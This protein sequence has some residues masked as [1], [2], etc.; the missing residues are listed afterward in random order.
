VKHSIPPRPSG[1]GSSRGR[2]SARAEAEALRSEIV[3]IEERIREVRRGDGHTPQRL[4]RAMELLADIERDLHA[5]AARCGDGGPAAPA[6]DAAAVLADVQQMRSAC[7]RLGL[8][9]CVRRADAVIAGHVEKSARAWGEGLRPELGRLDADGCFRS[10]IETTALDLEARR[11]MPGG[12]TDGETFL[13]FRATLRV[14]LVQAARKSP[15]GADVRAEWTRELI[16]RGDT[17]LTSVEGEPPD[18]AAALLGVVEADITWHLEHVETA[19]GPNRRRLLRKRW[20]LRVEQQERVLQG[21]LQRRFGPTLVR[22]FERLI[23]VLIAL[24]VPL[25]FVEAAADL[26]RTTQIWI[27]VFDGA[28]CLLFLTEFFVKLW[29]VPGKWLWFR[30]HALIDLVPSIPIGLLLFTFPAAGGVNAWIKGFRLWR[31]ARYLRAFGLVSRGLDRLARQY[32]HLLNQNVILYPTREELARSWAA[33]PVRATGL[34]RLRRELRDC[35]KHLVRTADEGERLRVAMS[36]LDVLEDVLDRS[37]ACGA[38][39]RRRAPGHAREVAAEVL[40]DNLVVM[41]AEDAEAALGDELVSQTA[42]IVRAAAWAP[43]RWLPIISSVVP[44]LT[45][46]MSDAEITAAT[47]RR[48]GRL[49]KRLHG[50]WFWV[51]DLYGTVTPSQ[52]VDRV[53]TMLVRSSSRPAYRLVMFGGLYVLTLLLIAWLR[54][55]ELDPVK[56]F[57]ER[58]VGPLVLVLGIVAGLVLGV[59]IWLQRVAQEATEFYERSAKAQ[60]LHLTEVI[61]SRYLRRDAGVLYDRILRSEWCPDPGSCGPLR[62]HHLAVVLEHIHGSLTEATV[63]TDDDALYRGFDTVLLLYRDWLDGAILTDNDTRST[64]QLLGNPAVRQIIMLSGR[65]GRGE[66]KRL[67][68]LDLERQKAL[69]GGPYLWFNFICRAVAHSV[70]SLLVDYNQNAVRLTE[71]PLLGPPARQRYNRWLGAA[72]EESLKT[73][74]TDEARVEEHYV[75]TVFTA[76]HFLDFDP[77]RDAEVAQE[78]GEPVLARLRRDRS[79]LIRTIFGTYP[80]HNRPKE[81]RV[82]NLYSLYGSWLSGGRLVLLPLFVAMLGLR[83]LWALLKWIGRSVQEVRRPEKRRD[84][85][86]AAQAHFLTAVR[87]VERIRGPVVYAGLRLRARLDAEY[88][89]VP[90]PNLP[91][92]PLPADVDIDLDFLHAEPDVIREVEDERRRAAADM[93][94]L[95]VLF[96]GGLLARAARRRALPEDAFSSA[97]HHRAAAV[98]YLSDMRG[99]RRHL[100]ADRIVEEVI[101][102]AVTE[103]PSAAPWRPAPRLRRA[104]RRYWKQHGIGDRLGRRAAWRAVRRNTWGAADSL[105]AAHRHGAKA[106]DEG[107]RLLGELL[108]H[109]SRIIDQLVTV[110]AIQTLAV[111]D[112]LNYREHIHALGRYAD[113]GDLPGELLDWN[114]DR[115][116]AF[117]E[118]PTTGQQAIAG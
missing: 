109:P 48:C 100:S 56:L 113:S 28:A 69:F 59:G 74:D 86:E 1:S 94:R 52:F 90:L 71:L 6:H 45:A 83:L 93:D 91:P 77:Q 67:Q 54:I 88:L 12:R 117:P 63:G 30:R 23:L 53:G 70:A 8:D 26:S 72:T 96:E 27:N 9:E 104:F 24:V 36:R 98:A 16:D 10:L 103:P 92:P 47:A 55:T 78:F 38:D 37:V 25:V 13:E 76:L 105:M 107:E 35:W 95:R 118:A 57:L 108:L 81:Q 42:R 34:R 75:T 50:A 80:M 5:L 111:L 21:R 20:Q 79:F 3:A 112:V 106:A 18:R 41:T 11:H 89:G 114:T 60:F 2:Q 31:F 116:A 46:G 39:V 40:I 84:H 15:P 64:S 19:G 99:V 22:R 49:L 85:S 4:G 110:R 82:V 32:G 97:D 14:A 68:R 61:R 33:V 43:L 58:S 101:A 115:A 73:T 62:D 44:R 7:E 65:I 17:A 102:Q 87:K 66:E 51:A 29:Y